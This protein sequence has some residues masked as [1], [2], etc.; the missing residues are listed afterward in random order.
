MEFPLGAKIGIVAGLLGGLAGLGVAVVMAPAIGI[1]IAV[2]TIAFITWIFLKMFRPLLRRKR[3]L[4]TG[5]RARGVINKMWDTGL[6]VNDEPRIGVDM[7]IYPPEGHPIPVTTHFLISRLQTHLYQP[8]NEFTVRYDPQRPDHVAV[9]SAG[10]ISEGE[11]DHMRAKL[12]QIDDF[13]QTVNQF[14][15]SAS[16]IVLDLEEDGP[17]INGDIFI[18]RLRVKILAKGRD[19]FEGRL[20]GLFREASLPIYQPGKEIYVK[21][22]EQGML[23]VAVDVERMRKG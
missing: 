15:T 19:P 13:N 18:L 6:S 10:F 14:G 22:R 17:P 2:V 20:S 4:K 12:E 9:E 7:T 23:E 16:A 1:P 21:F 8:G 11:M 5:V 3:L